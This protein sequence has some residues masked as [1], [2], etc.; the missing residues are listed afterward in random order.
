MEV[1]IKII[2]FFT[3]L[4]SS[5]NVQAQ[6]NPCPPQ[7]C[8]GNNIPIHFPFTLQGQQQPQNCSGYP[9]FSLTCSGEIEGRGVPLLTLPHSG[10]FSVRLPQAKDPSLRR[11]P[12]PSAEAHG[13]KPHLLALRAR[14][15]GRVH[16]PQ[17]PPLRGG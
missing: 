11:R 7:Q 12:L 6:T 8:G 4:L 13:S 10:N 17:L 3:Y 9:G 16:L 14:I 15:H 1:L 2:L 5:H